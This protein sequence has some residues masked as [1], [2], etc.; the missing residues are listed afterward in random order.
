MT[1]ARELAHWAM[2]LL[3]GEDCGRY[4]DTCDEDCD[5]LTAA[6]EARDAELIEACAQVADDSHL[7]HC[8]RCIRA[9]LAPG[10]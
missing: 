5:A 10:R 4:C 3:V 8:A 7:E 6:I 9:L 2:R 1:P